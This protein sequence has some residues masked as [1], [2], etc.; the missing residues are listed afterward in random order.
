MTKSI[1]VQN[2]RYAGATVGDVVRALAKPRKRKPQK[3]KAEQS[4]TI[5]LDD[6]VVR[7]QRSRNGK[8]ES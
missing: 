4:E 6:S 2:P 5:E 7:F 8:P 3:S 1:K